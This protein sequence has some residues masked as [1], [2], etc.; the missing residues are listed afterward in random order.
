MTARTRRRPVAARRDPYAEVTARILAA[1]ERGTVPWRHPWRARGLRNAVSHR[2]YRGINLLVLSLASMEAGYDDARWLTFRQAEQLGGHVRRG[3]HGTRVVLWKWPARDEGGTDNV[4]SANEER[5]GAFP[6]MRLYTVFN[7]AQ[8]EGLSL[9]DPESGGEF[10]P[11][12]RAEAIVS[13]YAGGPD[14]LHDAAAAYYVPARDEVHLPP[15]S[16]FRDTDGY[17]ATLFHELAHST[18]HPSRLDR[19]GYQESAP[20][21]SPVYSREELVAEFA[22][23]FLCQEAGVDASRLDQSAAYIASWLRALQDDRRLAVAAAG[24]AQRAVDHILGRDPQ[25]AVTPVHEEEH[26][27]V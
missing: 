21:G 7:V 24:Q 10:G 13:G 2:P 17:Y 5:R 22:A 26:A 14:V 3:E 12:E 15:R 20:F 4:D 18:G 16:A 11:L 25:A 23:A 6:L 1:L 27:D 8:C 9:P 19:E